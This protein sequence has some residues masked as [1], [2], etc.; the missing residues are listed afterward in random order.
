MNLPAYSLGFNADAAFWGW[1][2]EEAT[3]NLCL[4]TKS[5]AQERVNSFLA[6]L[7]NCRE[8][9][10]RRCRTVLQSRAEALRQTPG[11]AP[12]SRRMHIPPWLWFSS[13]RWALRGYGAPRE[14]SKE[15]WSL[16]SLPKGYF[17]ARNPTNAAGQGPFEW[18]GSKGVSASPVSLPAAGYG[19]PAGPAGRPRAG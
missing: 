2:R 12:N 11:P 17:A 4:G 7:S 13:E 19:G 9:V 1:A 16:P 5:A 8:E 14:T 18:N 10:K 3:G 15:N 6:G